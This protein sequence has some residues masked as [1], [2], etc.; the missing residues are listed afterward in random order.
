MPMA[1]RLIAYVIKAEVDFQKELKINLYYLK[2]NAASYQSCKK[3][4]LKN[5]TL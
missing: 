1:K 4:K 2:R 3:Q 5:Y